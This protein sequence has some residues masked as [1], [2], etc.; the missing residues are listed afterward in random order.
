MFLFYV[1][2]FFEKGDT[3]QGGTLLKG[4]L[5]LGKYVIY[6]FE[7]SQPLKLFCKLLIV[8]KADNF[9][10]ILFSILKSLKFDSHM[11]ILALNNITMK[12]E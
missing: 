9:E 10:I 11:L 8:F 6:Q 5:Y 7:T 12:R 2:S 4:G 3:I 1:L